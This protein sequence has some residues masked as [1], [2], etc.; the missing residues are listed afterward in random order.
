MNGPIIAVGVLAFE[1]AAGV[2]PRGSFKVAA[3]LRMELSGFAFF[4][5]ECWVLTGDKVG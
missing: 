5:G 3:T 1:D 4:T 2:D